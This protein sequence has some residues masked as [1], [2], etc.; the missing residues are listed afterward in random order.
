MPADLMAM[1]RSI[2]AD[3]AGEIGEVSEE[4]PGPNATSLAS[5]AYLARDPRR[6]GGPEPADPT[7]L[8]HDLLDGAA[9]GSGLDRMRF[10]RLAAASGWAVTERRGVVIAQTPEGRIA[11]AITKVPAIGPARR[12]MHRPQRE[13]QAPEG[14]VL[15]PAQRCGLAWLQDELGFWCVVCGGTFDPSTCEAT[16]RARR[17]G[18]PAKRN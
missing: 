8:L 11:A 14:P 6:E 12:P 16:G 4:S 10:G 5:I 2:L 9:H 18:E 7:Q 15:S 1:A 17:G 13:L 3:I